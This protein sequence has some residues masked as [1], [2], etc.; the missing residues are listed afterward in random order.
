[1]LQTGYKP[2][3]MSGNDYAS[4]LGG[5]AMRIAHYYSK[6]LPVIGNTRG[7]VLSGLH[8]IRKSSWA[9]NSLGYMISSF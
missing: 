1:M 4:P 2:L 7:L 3:T 6:S 9:Y 5:S 8:H